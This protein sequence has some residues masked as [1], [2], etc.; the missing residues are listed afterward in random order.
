MN[1]AYLVDHLFLPPKLPQEDDSSLDGPQALLSHVKESATAFVQKLREKNVDG[2]I[3]RS[4]ARLRKTF[5]WM[6]DLHVK[7]LLPLESL[8]GAISGMD[9]DGALSLSTTSS[10][11]LFLPLICSSSPYRRPKCWNHH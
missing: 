11:N 5:K 4:W 10:S 9:V 8:N 2:D 7:G 1:L 6:D 3:I